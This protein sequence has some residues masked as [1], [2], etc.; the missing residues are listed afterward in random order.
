MEELAAETALPPDKLREMLAV[1][2]YEGKVI[3]RGG[4]YDKGEG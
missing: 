3:N 1:L 2:I 4:L